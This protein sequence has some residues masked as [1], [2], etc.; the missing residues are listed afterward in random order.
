M[1]LSRGDLNEI[2]SKLK[3]L[4]QGENDQ[5]QLRKEI[6]DQGRKM[7]ELRAEHEQQIYETTLQ[8]NQKMEALQDK[9]EQERK[10]YSLKLKDEIQLKNDKIK[11]LERQQQ[12]DKAIR[13]QAESTM[14]LMDEL[15]E[16]K[17]MVASE[18]DI[19]RQENGILQERVQKMNDDIT[20][21]R[22]R[23]NANYRP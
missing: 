16:Q 18:R 22:D 17:K 1:Q 12:K 2:T 6:I 23:L 21:L 11:D 7:N 10:K 15:K 20:Q 14:R 5:D 4:T 9:V 19:I 13:L 8:N 3:Q